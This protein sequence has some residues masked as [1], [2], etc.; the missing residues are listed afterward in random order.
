MLLCWRLGFCGCPASPRCP[1][2]SAHTATGPRK[3]ARVGTGFDTQLW[4][5]SSSFSLTALV[6]AAMRSASMSALLSSASACAARTW[7]LNFSLVSPGSAGVS[8]ALES[9]KVIALPDFSIFYHLVRCTRSI[10]TAADVS[11]HQATDSESSTPWNRFW[12]LAERSH[13]SD[14]ARLLT[15]AVPQQPNYPRPGQRS[16]DQ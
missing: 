16:W 10:L 5:F 9:G 1:T 13:Q 7:L 8:L 11:D 12:S 2:Q 15:I 6:L 4:S 14:Q 3:T